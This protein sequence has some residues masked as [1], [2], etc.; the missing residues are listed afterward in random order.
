MSESR[1]V[2]PL[3]SDAEVK[4]QFPND[5]EAVEAGM[6]ALVSRA[7]GAPCELWMNSRTYATFRLLGRGRGWFGG[8]DA[9]ITLSRGHVAWL[10][11]APVRIDLEMRECDVELRSGPQ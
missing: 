2:L 7:R 1:F 4:A 10:F 11:G 8:V 6:R 5:V 3:L 9:G